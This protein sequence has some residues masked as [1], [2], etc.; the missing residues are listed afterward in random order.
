LG[1]D[2]V[3]EAGEPLRQLAQKQALATDTSASTDPSEAMC[4]LCIFPETRRV[5]IRLASEGVRLAAGSA[6]TLYWH[7]GS[8]LFNQEKSCH[9]R[10]VAR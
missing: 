10:I 6:R 1:A 3:A 2:A 7:S 9:Y 5:C 4:S 8:H